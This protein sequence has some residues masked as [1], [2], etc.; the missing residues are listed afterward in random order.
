[1]RWRS[2]S[3]GVDTLCISGFMDDVIFA[4]NRSH[5]GKSIYHCSEWRHR[6]FMHRITPLLHHI[7]E[8]GADGGPCNGPCPVKDWKFLLD[9][10]FTACMP[11][12]RVTST[13][14]LGIRRWSSPQQCYLH[15]LRIATLS[16]YIY[17]DTNEW[18]SP[19]NV[20]AAGCLLCQ[21]MAYHWSWRDAVWT[22]KTASWALQHQHQ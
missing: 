16:T 14:G 8:K 3:G 4:N 18:H 13:F 1:M 17:E 10:S 22:G 5:G 21:W 19:V 15:C 6:V 12:L 9:Q 20:Y 7:G 2:S 11:L